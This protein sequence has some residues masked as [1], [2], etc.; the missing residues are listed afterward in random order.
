MYII[1]GSLT[2][3][4][5]CIHRTLQGYF[6]ALTRLLFSH[7]HSFSLTAFKLPGERKNSLAVM[8]MSIIRHKR[9]AYHAMHVFVITALKYLL[10]CFSF[11]LFGSLLIII[12]VWREIDT[13]WKFNGFGFVFKPA[14]VKP[15]SKLVEPSHRY[16]GFDS[17]YTHTHTFTADMSVKK[18]NIM[19]EMQ[20]TF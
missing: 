1:F 10:L 4:S 13:Y 9:L 17:L 7:S 18:S 14:V 12:I 3:H 19:K 5:I 8:E 6:N 2:F 15:V 11:L 20:L 16:N